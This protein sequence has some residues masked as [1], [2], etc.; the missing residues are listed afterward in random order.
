[1]GEEEWNRR[2]VRRKWRMSYANNMEV[3]Q[4]CQNTLMGLFYQQRPQVNSRRNGREKRKSIQKI[5]KLIIRLITQLLIIYLI[6]TSNILRAIH[7]FRNHMKSKLT[8]ASGAIPR[9]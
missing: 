2:I 7:W 6:N 1:M 4:R 3:Y 5:M 8:I 9:D